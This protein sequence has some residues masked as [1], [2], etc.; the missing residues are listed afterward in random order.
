M[1]QTSSDRPGWAWWGA[2]PAG[3]LPLRHAVR[4]L[5]AAAPLEEV[6]FSGGRP[7]DR[8]LRHYQAEHPKMGR[9]DRLLLGTALYGLARN[10]ELLRCVLPDALPGDGEHLILAFLDARGEDPGKVAH[11]PGGPLV[12]VQRLEAADSL[13]RRWTATLEASWKAP[14]TGLPRAVSE[15]LEGLLGVPAWWLRE[16][17][18]GTIGEAV[19]ELAKLKRPQNLILRAQPATPEGR[20]GALA[21]L[22]DLGVPCRPTRRSP[23]GIVV[24]GRHNVLGSAPYREGRI[25]VQD[26][27]SQLVVCLCDPKPGERV[28]DYC[29]GGGGK[30]LALGA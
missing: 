3:E 6:V 7:L 12:W 20:A 15:A 30:A 23:W 16:G 25:E 19:R 4:I 28:L 2:R 1:S 14:P 10:R 26:E 11:L 21:G 29:A 9:T 22:R 5:R 18:W 24:D 8:A 13:R 17:P 27:G